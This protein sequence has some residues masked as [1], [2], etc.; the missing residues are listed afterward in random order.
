MAENPLLEID[1]RD[2]V[3][4]TCALVDFP[5]VSHEEEALCDAL[6]EWIS[7]FRS[8]ATV[9]RV[10]NSL[11]VGIGAQKNP[12]VF[13]GHIDTVPATQYDGELN[14]TARQNGERIFGLG[15]SD[16]KSGVAIMIALLADIQIPS[17]FVFYE[18]EEVEEK[19]SGLKKIIDEQP[20]LVNNAAWAILLEPTDGQIE[21]GCQGSITA[22]ARF[23]GLRAHSARPWLGENAIH[24]SLAVAERAVDHSQSQHEVEILSLT[25]TPS[26]SVT[27]INGGF[28]DNVIPDE[29]EIAINHRFT[30]NVSQEKAQSYVIEEIC[31][32]ADSVEVTSV[33]AGAMPAFGHP[34]VTFAQNN[35]RE[36]VPK[37]GWTDVS[38]FYALGIDAVNCGPGDANLAHKADE[39]VLVSKINDTYALLKSFIDSL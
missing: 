5:S 17:T 24:K 16:M 22:I 12:V 10:A 20:E 32:G 1:P 37:L 14:A 31:A 6:A 30:P 21:M 23:N 18:C 7:S 8:D 26:L 28:S 35:G 34:L 15:S 29:C 13:A 11:V 9:T 33:S 19:Y 27:R 25:F 2:P 3:A 39:H 36:L 4:T 38:R